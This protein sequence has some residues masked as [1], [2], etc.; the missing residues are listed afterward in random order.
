MR[1][2]IIATFIKDP[3][4]LLQ[5]FFMQCYKCKYAKA[6]RCGDIT[7]G[8]CANA[9][10]FPAFADKVLSTITINTEKGKELW[11]EACE[12]FLFT[13]AD[14]KTETTKNSQLHQPVIRSG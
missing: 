12:Q 1:K 14:Y 3:L 11:R 9:A 10:A 4:L 7:S 6:E 13:D 5:H 2:K 8:D